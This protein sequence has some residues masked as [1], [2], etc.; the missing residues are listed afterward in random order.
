[1]KIDVV[2]LVKTSFF[3]IVFLGLTTL[4]IQSALSAEK[5][6]TYA[7]SATPM[8]ANADVTPDEAYRQLVAGNA[9]YL[10]ED[11]DAARTLPRTST[12]HNRFPIATVVYSADMPV[13]PTALTQMSDHD[14]YLNVVESGV[15]S[16]D[17]L[18]AVEYGLINLQTPL[19]VVMGHYPSR[20][21]SSLIRDFDAL[22]ARAE[23]ESAKATASG[24]NATGA[25]PAQMKLY[26]LIGPA[27]SRSREAYPDLEGYD[28]TN[29]VSEAL[30]WQSLETILMKSTV[31]QDLIKAGKLNLIAAI[32]D[33]KTG[34]IYWLGSHP[35]QEEFLKPTP[36][37]IQNKTETVSV[38]TEADYTEPLDDTTVQEYIT[39]YENEPYYE[40]VV[41]EYYTQPVYYRPSWELFS[42]R[43]WVYRPWYGVWYTRFRPWPYWS[44]WGVPY[45]GSGLGVSIWDGRISFFIGFNRHIGPPIYYDPHFRPRDPWWG[46]DYF[47]DIAVRHHDIVFDLIIGGHRHDIPFGPHPWGPGHGPGHGPGPHFPGGYHP[48]AARP[49]VVIGIG[50]INININRHGPREPGRPGG[51][52][53]PGVGGPAGRPGANPGRPGRPDANPGRPAGRPDANPGRPA[54]RP[55]ANPGSTAGRPDANSGR[56]AG[57]PGGNPG[58]SAER[59]SVNSGG[60]AGRS[61]GGRAGGGPGR[62]VNLQQPTSSGLF[63]RNSISQ[64]SGARTPGA[65]FQTIRGQENSSQRNEMSFFGSRSSTPGADRSSIR[66]GSFN[67]EAASHSSSFLGGRPGQNA[68]SLNSPSTRAGSPFSAGAS[69]SRSGGFTPTGMG[70]N[71]A[72]GGPA[73]GMGAGLSRGGFA[74]SGMG[75]NP[76]H[77]GPAG[78]MGAGPSH[79]GF[80]PS[81]MGAGP[82]HGSPGGGMGPGPRH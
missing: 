51:P 70:P 24:P 35:L 67:A 37:N 45:G 30:V 46:S 77:G 56:P 20:T 10:K 39:T 31:A 4:A 52:V 71:P 27:I 75:P 19:L 54:G 11:S 76:A 60:P 34:K 68:S 63:A 81:G 74:S 12:E 82:S 1:M 58:G 64:G 53:G 78:G 25:T 43:A 21:V 15:V 38:L 50:N 40:D 2:K 41:T 32:A 55:D 80:T 57:R 48:G 73:G 22:E 23:K 36:E 13:K 44:P 18:S 47:F 8:Y 59:P 49:G 14:V 61:P 6:A 16:T 72:H 26:N 66:S 33:D 69:P 7:D 28:L 29:V 42:P 9:R 5:T 3:P 17:D 79:G 65:D 62:T